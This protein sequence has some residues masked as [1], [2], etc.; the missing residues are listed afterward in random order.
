MIQSNCYDSITSF[1]RPLL[2]AIFL[3]LL[4][5][6]EACS[7]SPLLRCQFGRSD[8]QR[9][10]DFVPVSDPYTIKAVD[11]DGRFRFKAVVV[12]NQQSINYITLNVYYQEKHQWKLL[13]QVKY[14]PPFKEND[15][16]P[17]NLTGANYVYSPILGREFQYSCSLIKAAP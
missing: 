7:A 3:F 13:H 2:Y 1:G 10:V 17:Y 6:D 15:F 4:P 8:D 12:G 16:S 9:T 11:I 5:V 14:F